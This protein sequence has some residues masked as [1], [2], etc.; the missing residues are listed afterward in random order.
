MLDK[1][2]KLKSRLLV[3]QMHILRGADSSRRQYYKQLER[4]LTRTKK[5]ISSFIHITNHRG[6]LTPLQL[7]INDQAIITDT[8]LCKKLRTITEWCNL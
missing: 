1:T 4:K 3:K 2:K 8:I 7:A 5:L 6:I